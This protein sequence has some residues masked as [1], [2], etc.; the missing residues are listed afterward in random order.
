V[1]RF[2]KSKNTIVDYYL[3]V[4]CAPNNSALTDVM[5]RNKFEYFSNVITEYIRT[6]IVL[7]KFSYISVIDTSLFQP[8]SQQSAVMED[9]Y[10]LV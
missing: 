10:I 6:N 4:L 1:A 7:C 8:H 5:G 9:T 3:E 2:L